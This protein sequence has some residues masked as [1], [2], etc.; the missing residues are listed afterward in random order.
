MSAQK[1]MRYTQ[2]LSRIGRGAFAPYFAAAIILAS[3]AWLLRYDITRKAREAPPFR[4]GRDRAEREA[5]HVVAF[6]IIAP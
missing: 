2:N 4:A 1:D 6:R 3:A 5:C